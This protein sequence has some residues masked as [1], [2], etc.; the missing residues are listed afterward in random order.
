MRK[1][2]VYIWLCLLGTTQAVAQESVTLRTVPFEVKNL[3]FHVAQVIDDRQEKRLG[4]VK[5]Q[6]ANKVDLKLKEG[7]SKAVQ[8]FINVSFSK[9]KNGQPIYIKIKALDVQES[10]ISVAEVTARAHIELVFYEKKKNKLKQVYQIKH[11][12]DQYFALSDRE[13]RFNTHE[14]RVRAAL[15]YCLLA[16]IDNYSKTNKDVPIKHFPE[17]QST[18]DFDTR[19]G[20]WFNLVTVRGIMNSTYHRGW[21]VSYTGFVDSDKSF[22]IP[23]EIAMNF[24]DVKSDIAINRGYASVE[25]YVLQP[26]LYGY[27]K[28][29][30]GVYAALGVQVPLGVELL[31][32]LEGRRST[33]FVVGVGASQG[34][35]IIPWSKFGLVLGVEF[36]QQIQTSR[37][38][39]RDVGLEI[40]LG[41]NF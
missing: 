2:Q 25:S 7:A 30:P 5:D 18:A 6:E 22:I 35:K 27:K 41:V 16:F 40:I 1:Y 32:N 29:F 3:S 14:K 13:E 10:Q 15:E 12:E 11:N 4:Q 21:A 24:Y 38:Y 17:V 39:Q 34:I 31:E 8:D 33:N 20:K 36:F 37:I 26:G 19:L 23:Y 9:G 28:L